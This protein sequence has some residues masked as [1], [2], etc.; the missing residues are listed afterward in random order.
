MEHKDVRF[1][2]KAVDEDGTI[3]GYAAVFGN[4]DLG[5]DVIGVGAFTKTLGESKG[6]V[7]LMWQHSAPAGLT[8]E[9][10]PD[11]NGLYMK[12][13]LLLTT[14]TGREAYEFAKAGVVRGLSIGYDAMQVGWKGGARVLEEIKLFEISLVTIPMNPQA[15]VLAVKG[16]LPFSDLPLGDKGRAWDALGAC[17]RIWAWAGGDDALDVAKF[18]RGF[19]WYD[20][21]LDAKTRGAYKLPFADIIDGT[22]TAIP[23][24]IYA[25]AAV[26]QGARGGANIPPAD[27]ERCKAHL[28]RY[29]AK[30]DETSPWAKGEGPEETTE[31]EPLDL[32]ALPQAA[33]SKTSEPERDHS[34]AVVW[35]A[36]MSNAIHVKE[37]C[38][39]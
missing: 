9:L 11:S 8:S 3:E 26:L 33:A 22:L 35:D 29:Y 4:V 10:T 25:A 2:V 21:D 7:P 39:V 12:A 24:G 16:V 38:D 36:L 32:Q 19:L 6:Q 31:R 5:G 28:A 30:L 1:R 13:R 37:F 18:R 34:L 15:Q 23:R 27:Q 20:P 17:T 14:I